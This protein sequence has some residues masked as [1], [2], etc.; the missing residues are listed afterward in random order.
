MPATKPT[1]LHVSLWSWDQQ[2]L[3]QFNLSQKSCQAESYVF[4]FCRMLDFLMFSPSFMKSSRE[5][6]R[7]AS[8]L[9]KWMLKSGFQVLLYRAKE[10]QKSMKSTE[11]VK[12][13]NRNFSGEGL[14]LRPARGATSWARSP[15]CRRAWRRCCR[16]SPA[17]CRANPGPRDGSSRQGKRAETETRFWNKKLFWS[18]LE[19]SKFLLQHWADKYQLNIFHAIRKKSFSTGIKVIV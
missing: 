3:C 2:L 15:G 19:S 12:K 17:S 10:A 9:V 7:G 8:L 18:S 6:L 13:F 5:F 1:P 14:P 11:W 4:K 16:E